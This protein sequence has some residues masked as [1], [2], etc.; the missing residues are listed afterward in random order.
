MVRVGLK[1]DLAFL[2]RLVRFF[3]R[4]VSVKY[5]Q[6]RGRDLVLI[7]EHSPEIDTQDNITQ[8]Q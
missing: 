5:I 1:I 8:V 3:G 4:P 6:R 7:L 2:M